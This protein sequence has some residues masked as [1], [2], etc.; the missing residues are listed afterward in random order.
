MTIKE[1][2]LCY[3]VG[4]HASQFNGRVVTALRYEPMARL[5]HAVSGT[6]Y[7]GPAWFVDAANIGFVGEFGIPPEHLKPLHDPDA[8]ID[9][10]AALDEEI[11]R[12]RQMAGLS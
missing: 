6:E 1:G 8:D 12:V 5:Y 7:D 4:L 11:M 10:S 2:S 9:E 3:V